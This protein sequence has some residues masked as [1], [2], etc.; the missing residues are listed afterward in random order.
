MAKQMRKVRVGS[1]VSTSMDRTAVVDMVWKQRHRLYRKQMRRVARFYIHDPENQ[2]RLGD[3]VRIQETRPISKTKHWRLLEILQRRQMAEVRPFELETDIETA[4]AGVE[5]SVEAALEGLETGG[6]DTA[7]EEPE[8]AAAESAPEAPA[9]A[10][11]QRSPRSRRGTADP[12]EEE[13]ETAAE[14]P[15]AEADESSEATVEEQEAGEADSAE[16]EPET[17]TE[18][19]IAEADESG[20]AAVE[21]LETGTA[22][23]AEE[24]SKE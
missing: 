9:P 1:V 3:T 17:G 23:S 12:A 11:R 15:I 20:E 4:I 7:E 22:D 6:A 10:R 5:E 2:C 14:T 24:E 13:L 21:E 16:E 8:T 18:T 19:P